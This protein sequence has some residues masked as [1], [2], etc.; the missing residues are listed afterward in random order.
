MANT[1]DEFS[2]KK[3]LKRTPTF[4]LDESGTESSPVARS[5]SLMRKTSSLLT[6]LD[7]DQIVRSL[8]IGQGVLEAQIEAILIPAESVFFLLFLSMKIQ[9]SDQ[10]CRKC[11]CGLDRISKNIER[12]SN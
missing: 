9:V 2:T 4:T 10:S 12:H 8:S 1:S 11:C 5:A 7:T 6:L 3:P